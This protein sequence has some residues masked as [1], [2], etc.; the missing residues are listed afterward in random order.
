MAS[1]NFQKVISLNLNLI[2]DRLLL[3]KIR[4]ERVG[5]GGH[6]TLGQDLFLVLFHLVGH[7][8]VPVEEVLD[9]FSSQEELVLGLVLVLTGRRYLVTIVVVVENALRHKWRLD[10][11]FHQLHPWEVF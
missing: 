8:T 9:A 7:V 2:P 10:L 4:V 5:G 3:V 11:L 6:V 1:L